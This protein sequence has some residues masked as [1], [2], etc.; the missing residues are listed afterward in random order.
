MAKN[1][2]ILPQIDT[3]DGMQF[4]LYSLGD[5]VPNPNTGERLSAKERLDQIVQLA[6]AAEQAGLDI[7]HVG[8]SH[9][10][11]FVS[12]AHMVILSAIAQATKNIRI[13]SATTIVSTSDPVRTFEDAATIDLLSNGR[14][15]IVAGR[16]SRLGLFELL[17]YNKAD[18][19]ELFEERFNLL[20]AIN[21][22]ETIN[23]SGKYRAPL[24]EAHV[25]PRPD[26]AKQGLPIWRAVGGR[27]DSAIKAGDA[28]V[29]MYITTLG[30]KL[31]NFTYAVSEYRKHAQA[32]GYDT[33][34]L[35]LTTAGFLYLDTHQQRAEET[36]FPYVDQ[37]MKRANGVG[38]SR[39]QY[40][41]IKDTD[42]TL[43]IGEPQLVIDKLLAQYEAFGMQRYV[44]QID[45]GGQSTKQIMQ[46]LE[47]LATKVIPTVKKY[48]K[49]K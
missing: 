11:Y 32:A 21:E 42:S 19:G 13:G 17:G 41:Q 46:T 3:T 35:P 34:E 18:Y 33:D 6:T 38:F 5:H 47:L 12:Q 7:F 44:A 30:G 14:M 23:W 43:N 22:N 48:T 29:P 9:Q 26:S 24:H 2:H 37:A 4:G 15:E 31:E 49:K 10:E 45:F 28:G 40:S 36:F 39:L 25:I 27:A 20:L 1:P 16:A 8:E